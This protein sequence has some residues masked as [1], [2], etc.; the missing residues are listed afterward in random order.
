MAFLG[1]CVIGRLS[2]SRI[3]NL[4]PKCVLV[5]IEWHRHHEVLYTVRD[6]ECMGKMVVDNVRYLMNTILYYQCP[7][8]QG[9]PFL[10][11]AKLDRNQ[12][13]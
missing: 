4:L 1:E 3:S 5:A 6:N 9:P 13:L 12:A 10:V 7:L 11:S 8:D 2:P